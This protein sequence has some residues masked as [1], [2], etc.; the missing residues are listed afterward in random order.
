MDPWDIV[1]ETSPARAPSPRRS[2]D[3][4]P[5]P[6]SLFACDSNPFGV[7]AAFQAASS[8]ASLPPQ[9]HPPSRGLKKVQSAQTGKKVLTESGRAGGND[10]HD[11]SL[12]NMWK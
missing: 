6:L 4:T 3:G 10:K 7:M 8:S 11:N 9:V 1:A 5:V 2:Q 12:E